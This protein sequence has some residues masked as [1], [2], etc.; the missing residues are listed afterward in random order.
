M[1]TDTKNRMFEGQVALITGAGRGVGR[2]VALMLAAHGAS[3]VINDL[4]EAPATETVATIQELGGRATA[5][6]G[7]VTQDDFADRFIGAAITEYGR[8]DILINNAGYTWDSLIHQMTDEQFQ[9]MLD[10]HLITPFRLIR[11]AAPYMREA[12][13]GE[14]AAGDQARSRKI[15]NVS[16]VAGVTGNVGQANYA[17]AKAGLI[18]LTKSVAKEWAPFNVHCNAVAFGLIDTRLTGA[19]E[20]G[21]TVQGIAVGIPE[22]VRQMFESSIPQKRAGTPEEAASAIFYLASPLSDYVTGQVLN[23]NGGMYT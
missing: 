12:A 16:S 4:D 11:A 5:V 3:V 7:N 19:K 2:A 21:E 13:K 6:I 23:I 20:K 22:K 18:G 8:L 1:T 9:A 15:V 10:M 14:I 17:S